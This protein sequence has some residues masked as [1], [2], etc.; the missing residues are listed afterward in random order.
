MINLI[1]Q[2][3]LILALLMPTAIS[4]DASGV[5]TRVL[6]GDTIEIQ[7]V[8]RIRLADV[9]CPE[10]NRLGGQEAAAF[11]TGIL[12]NKTVYLDIDSRSIHDNTESEREVCIVYLENGSN[13]N[14]MMVDTGHAYVQDYTSNEFSPADWWD[15]TIPANTSIEAV[16]GTPGAKII[17][18]ISVPNGK[19]YVGSKRSNKYHLPG[20]R[21][22]KRIN[23]EN[24][25]WFASA[26]D[27]EAHGYKPC[28]TCQDE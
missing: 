18:G 22:A 24:E 14:R 3:L 4:Y 21:W 7:D 16:N 9:D 1:L 15:G 5:V 11:A 6:D 10:M 25:I 12:L 19:E 27:A 17:P 8:G 26:E 23:P 28:G 2:A 20:C 13:F